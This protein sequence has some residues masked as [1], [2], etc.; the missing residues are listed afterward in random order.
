ML[1]VI[2]FFNCLFNRMEELFYLGVSSCV[3]KNNL[4]KLVFSM[5]IP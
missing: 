4:C 2:S 3:G 5:V 1:P